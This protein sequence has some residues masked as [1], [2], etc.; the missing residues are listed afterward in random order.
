MATN[1]INSL[2]GQLQDVVIDTIK[3]VQFG[4]PVVI[5]WLPHLDRLIEMF[6]CVD[7]EMHWLTRRLGA[8]W[9]MWPYQLLLLVS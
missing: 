5:G 9:I 4:M 6:N 8:L 2:V 7:V 3:V 1:R